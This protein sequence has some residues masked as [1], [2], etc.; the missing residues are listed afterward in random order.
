M[1]IG[2]TEVNPGERHEG[3][4]NI[5]EKDEFYQIPFIAVN[6]ALS[7][8]IIAILGGT[9]G[10]EYAGIE[11][12]LRVMRE[13]DPNQMSGAVIAVPVVNV[14]QFRHRT[15]FTS[16]IDGVN[17]NNVY[18]GDPEGSF[19]HRLAHLVFQDV[20]SKAD[21]LIDCHGG[22]LNEDIRGF[23]VASKGPDEELNRVSLEMASCYP[24]ELVHVF[25]ANPVG[26]GNSAQVVYGIPCIQPEAGT[27]VP[28]REE[29]VQF[30]IDGML[31]VLK[32]FGVT[33]G[34]PRRMKQHVSPDR[35]RLQSEINGIWHPRV[36]LDQ[37]V[38]KGDLLGTVSNLLGVEV[39]QVKAPEDGTVSMM[40]SHYSVRKDEL[41]LIVST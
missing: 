2:G 26:M 15:Q 25:P 10:T 11:A 13:L 38:R 29:D 24:C 32:Y 37:N 34:E 16:P 1:I 35:L 40:R 39:Q 19:T 3:Y 33:E 41:L 31:N 9:H 6:G 17:L 4:L 8:K 5:A 36:Y 12:V 20:V 21:A 23:V 27:P 22:D 18:P 30:H 14:P 28:T 7:G